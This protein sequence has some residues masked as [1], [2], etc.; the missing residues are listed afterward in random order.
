MDLDPA[1][2]PAGSMAASPADQLKTVIT[3][4]QDRLAACADPPLLSLPEEVLLSII[5]KLTRC[6]ACALARTCSTFLAAVLE[7]H[8]RPAASHV[9]AALVPLMARLRFA[10]V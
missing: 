2:L 10:Y 8:P 5:C 7:S 1:G 3:Q 6:A 9:P 4:Q